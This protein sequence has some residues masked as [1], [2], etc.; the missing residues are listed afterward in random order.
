MSNVSLVEC[1]SEQTNDTECST[2][3]LNINGTDEFDKQ[4]KI[5]V[6]LFLSVLYGTISIISVFGNALIIIV[7]FRSKRMQCV[8]N[9]F[10]SN[11]AVA[12]VVIGLF[13][14]PFQV[15]IFFSKL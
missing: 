11:L 6:I 10:I 5:F 13:A 14:T 4:N 15:F 2:N 12:D 3:Y 9:F 7:V 1:N 8:T